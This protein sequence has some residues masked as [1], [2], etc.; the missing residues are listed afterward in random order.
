MPGTI[1][2]FVSTAALATI[3]VAGSGADAPRAHAQDQTIK[4]VERAAPRL[5]R[6]FIQSA[7]GIADP[8]AGAME[9]LRARSKTPVYL[10]ARAGRLAAAEF[11]IPLPD[12]TGEPG[13]DA[14]AFLE[15]YAG[16]LQL[17][18]PRQTLYLARVE[19]SEDG[20][21]TVFF[22]QH[23]DGVSVFGGQIAVYLGKEA[24]TGIDGA[25]LTSFPP[26]MK[27]AVGADEAA[28]VALAD[29]R[30]TA[31]GATWTI[32]GSPRLMHYDP[33]LVDG[34]SAKDGASAVGER[35][36]WRDSTQAGGGGWKYGVDAQTGAILTRAPAEMTGLDYEIS[37]AAGGNEVWPCWV[38]R[39][40]GTVFAAD[41]APWFRETGPVAG[42]APDAEGVG[43]NG[44]LR[45]TYNAL[46]RFGR[47]AWD[48]R[49]GF[50]Y[51]GL[52]LAFIGSDPANG[53]N[54]A[55]YSP[56]CNNLAFTNNMAPQDVVAHEY[57]HGVVQFTANLNY[58]SLPGGAAT[59][60]ASLHEHYG[61]VVAALVDTSNWTVG[62]GTTIGII[63]DLQTPTNPSAANGGPDR[64]SNITASRS[65]H[66]NA[67]IPNKAFFL[68][69]A[70]QNF[71]N[72]LVT[73]V[74]RDAAG[75][76]WYETL[77]TRLVSAANFQSLATQAIALAG[78]W[79]ATGQNGFTA[80]TAC[81]VARAFSAVELDGDVDC[82][83]VRDS[84]D[85]SPDT[86]LDGFADASDNCRF[87]ANPSQLDTDRDG[88]GDACDADVDNDGRL[89][90]AD[91][92]PLVANPT[93]AD[94]NGD[95]AGD[96]C[97]DAD[98]DRVI[99]LADNC[100]LAP[101]ADQRN[102]DGDASGDA[103][104]ADVDNDGVCHMLDR[105]RFTGVTGAP[106]GGC[107]AREDNCPSTYN[108]AQDDGDS[109]GRGDACDQCPAAADT[110]RDTD[111]D[112][113]DDA[114]DA[115]IDNDGVANGADNCPET[116]NATQTD[117]D[118]DGV[119]QACD[120][121]EQFRTGPDRIPLDV[122]WRMRQNGLVYRVPLG[123]PA[124]EVGLDRTFGDGRQAIDIGFEA[125]TPVDIAVVDRLT[126]VEPGLSG[127]LL[128]PAPRD[129]C[130]LPGIKEG[131]LAADGAER[132]MIELTPLKPGKELGVSFEGAVV[133]YEKPVGKPVKD[134]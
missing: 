23:F 94:F 92:C 28:A 40:P 116:A 115:D 112:G 6:P 84:A 5:R 133:P 73:G 62:E 30:K 76:L 11:S 60:S 118:G 77:R 8:L 49:G 63:R 83:G 89:N 100:R 41:A 46:A 52:D 103:C 54:N 129:I 44:G 132:Y 3:V 69:A 126:G 107:P 45:A 113:Q 104:D 58:D 109:D 97:G 13:A 72:V 67:N 15:A 47:D 128:F 81:S 24:A 61:D 48:G 99:D 124:P 12:A 127:K 55:R 101:N 131:P 70:G 37:S 36:V 26:V 122:F 33:S 20:S 87:V 16:A 110:G 93:Q 106:S 19:Q 71:N 32:A 85:G 27:T 64:M 14:L 75:R 117:I 38:K 111:R 74:G 4:P 29:A 119:G 79:A 9:T 91:N 35:I 34:G 56:F 21:S 31:D 1:V 80:S 114:C 88:Q 95:G 65:P 57:G 50:M 121:D 59:Q 42:A 82:D 86:D 134:W 105:F 2:K 130:P 10:R 7:S 68:A 108:P 120:P 98:F 102:A 18:A 78:S 17:P 51:N 53:M 43:A 25:W 39:P 123:C 66:I 90:A 22:N 125:T 96:A